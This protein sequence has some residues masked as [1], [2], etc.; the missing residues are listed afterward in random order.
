MFE[1]DDE[2]VPCPPLTELAEPE[3]AAVPLELLPLEDP[4]EFDE[5]P[6]CTDPVGLVFVKPAVPGPAAAVSGALPAAAWVTWE[7][8]IRGRSA[9]R[10]A[11][12]VSKDAANADSVANAVSAAITP[13]RL[14]HRR[15]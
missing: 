12:V 3:D 5:V 2:D 15:T 7:A 6:V 11:D 10:G 1:S 8:S 9:A 4:L 14:V 13:M